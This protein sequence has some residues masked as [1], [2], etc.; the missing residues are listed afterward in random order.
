MKFSKLPPLMIACAFAACAIG[1]EPPP[2]ADGPFKPTWESLAQWKT[3]EWFRDAKF[4]VWAHWGAQSVPGCGDWYARNLY[5]ETNVAY[6][7]HTA[8]YGHPSAFGFKDV[9]PLW[10]AE[11]FDPTRLAALYKKAGAR[12]LVALA[13]HHDNFDNWDSTLQPW[14]SVR[15]GPKRDIVGQWKSAAAAQGMHF[16]VSIHNINSW[17][18]YDTTRGTDTKGPKAGIPYDGIMT[19][20][21]GKGKW[22]EGYDPGDLYGPVHKGGPNGDAPT[23]AFIAN[24]FHR[25]KELIDRYQPEILEFDLYSPTVVWRQWVKFEDVAGTPT[26]DQRVGMLL[27]AHYYNQERKWHQ[28]SDEGIITLKGLPPERRAQVTLALERDYSAEIMAQPWQMEE[29]M[30]DWFFQGENAAPYLTSSKV[31]AMLVEVVCRNGNLLLNVVMRPD[32]TVAGDQE[33]TLLKVGHWLDVN[34]EAIYGSRP[35]KRM[36]EGPNRIKTRAELLEEHRLFALPDYAPEDLR[37][38]TKGDSIY[39]I[40]LAVPTKELRI[41]SLAG[42]KVSEVTLLG[43]SEKLKWQ[44]TPEGLLIQPASQWPGELAVVFKIH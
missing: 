21:D 28:G 44:Q 18:W 5:D 8:H 12:Y 22:W 43:S 31:L 33:A 1:A 14:N 36:G 37:F 4:G 24:W 3:P 20:A 10:K 7:F 25:T 23:T 15:M 35:W 39:A 38:T 13:N 26:M 29:S 17:G 42:V 2:I 32:G 41:R 27:A 30:G 19:K 6:Q 11:K 16:G 9:I 40:A 34:G